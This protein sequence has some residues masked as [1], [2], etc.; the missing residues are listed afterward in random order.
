MQQGWQREVD[1]LITQTQENLLRCKRHGGTTFASQACD[2][3][4]Q[5]TPAGGDIPLAPLAGEEADQLVADK[6]MGMMSAVEDLRS[7]LHRHAAALDVVRATV[8][9]LQQPRARDLA[10]EQRLR[11]AEARLTGAE[12]VAAGAGAC[13]E[14]L[15][16]LR[17]AVASLGARVAALHGAT[18]AAG[19]GNAEDP[20]A[21]KRLAS[22]EQRMEDVAQAL[23]GLR[24]KLAESCDAQAAEAGWESGA[25]QEALVG[26]QAQ[27]EE[28]ATRAARGEHALACL[29][30]K[31]VNAYAAAEAGAEEAKVETDGLRNA[32]AELHG[33]VEEQV[34]ALQAQV[35]A[36]TVELAAARRATD[37]AAG[38][39]H[40]GAAV[41]GR[42]AALEQRLDE[43]AE[44]VFDLRVQMQNQQPVA[45]LGS[46]DTQQQL[47]AA[48]AA[49]GRAELAL[50]ELRAQVASLEAG[51]AQVQGDAGDTKQMLAALQEQ[52]ERLSQQ[53]Q[54]D[55][56]AVAGI[57]RQA[58]S[59]AV[60]AAE[61]RQGVGSLWQALSEL[62]EQAGLLR[63]QHERAA[64]AVLGMQSRLAG[65]EGPATAT[66][67]Q[68]GGLQQAVAA[69]QQGMAEVTAGQQQ[70]DGGESAELLQRQVDGLAAAVA[71]LQ[72][73]PPPPSHEQLT[74]LA[75]EVQ[76]V[77]AA[78]ELRVAR[79]EATT[80]QA[81]EEVARQMAA[82]QGCVA[83]AAGGGPASAAPTP[84]PSSAS[85]ARS[86]STVE[87]PLP[88]PAPVASL[89]RG[90]S[91]ASRVASPHGAS[92]R[93][94]SPRAASPH[95]A[96]P[97][98]SRLA[99]EGSQGPLATPRG[100]AALTEEIV[101]VE[102]ALAAPD[103]DDLE[104][105]ILESELSNLRARLQVVD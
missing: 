74:G 28:V 22:L 84:P 102:R 92:P 38:L 59:A 15:D 27:V 37:E 73:G 34:A 21:A 56:D 55:A 23:A 69:L 77:S 101:R 13:R 96:S 65:I 63:E 11:E 71:V 33:R 89:S 88:L 12:L 19:V 1:R 82:L 78:V 75:S 100:R 46:T 104:A 36:A 95:A 70:R 4:R 62:Q 31:V 3:A 7:D 54:Q 25:V 5:A 44:L 8:R 40:P 43:L 52:I 80:A 76:R 51:A 91:S 29:Q 85:A 66:E 2:R 50:E 60:A 42:V 41:E 97:R 86:A 58:D 57:S 87:A 26:L 81:L 94:S 24:A 17:D 90:G 48:A 61:A 35:T 67:Q 18:A 32:V 14:D 105:A 9:Q 68:L 103:L 98:G 64:E 16:V 99:S 30:A 53:R 93:G 45:A 6:T 39:E 79:L 47:E 20:A 10:L 83:A 49:Q 72:A